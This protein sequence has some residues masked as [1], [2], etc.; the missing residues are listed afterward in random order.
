MRKLGIPTV[1]DR[2][3]QQ[4]ILQVLNPI[5]N[6]TFS[7]SSFGFR[8]GKSAQQAIKQA[9]SFISQGLKYTVDIDLEAFFDTGNHDKMMQLLR[10]KIDDQRLLD[11]IRRY[12]NAGIMDQGVLVTS[13][14]GV[15][16]GG[17][18]SLLLSNVMLDVL[19]K[20]LDRRGHRY[21]RFAD[22]C[23][24]YV[25]SKRSAERVFES[26][27]QFLE[28]QLKLKVNLTKSA[29]DH[30][31]KRKFLGISFLT[32]DSVT[33]VRLAKKSEE[34]FKAR[35]RELTNRNWDVSLA[36]RIERINEYL[37]GWSAY[38]RVVETRSKWPELQGWLMRR[39]RAC[40][41]VQWKNPKTIYPSSSGQPGIHQL[42]SR[43]KAEER[44]QQEGL[45]HG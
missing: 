32:R 42:K 9:Q 3:A 41:L 6:P 39:L 30:A 12:L 11:I 17:P 13:E 15:P 14:T 44:Q 26:L 21:A 31:A 38:F 2:L 25:K 18:L 10:N 29:A 35:I 4:A 45:S 34:R 22:D 5:F 24:V 20:E 37:R 27:V 40:L 33:K 19:D 36:T 8:P 1:R 16:Q 23:N 43:C 28:K 7:D